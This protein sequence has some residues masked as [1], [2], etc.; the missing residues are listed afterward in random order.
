MSHFFLKVRNCID[1]WVNSIFV[2]QFHNY[3]DIDH[4]ITNGYHGSDPNNNLGGCITVN[5]GPYQH[6]AHEL[7]T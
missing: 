2:M 4:R 5:C 7:R 6:E 3:S 1:N